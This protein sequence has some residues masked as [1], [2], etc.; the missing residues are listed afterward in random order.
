MPAIKQGMQAD[1]RNLKCRPSL[2]SHPCSNEGVVQEMS[3]AGLIALLVR[4]LG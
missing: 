2:P 4:T 3:A 1:I